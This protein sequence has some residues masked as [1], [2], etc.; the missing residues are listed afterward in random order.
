MSGK[1]VSLNILNFCVA[2]LSLLSV[3]YFQLLK[4]SELKMPGRQTEKQSVY[5]L[6]ED[7]QKAKLNILSKLPAFG[8]DNL[9]ADWTFLSFLQYFGD[10]EDRQQTG[11]SLSPEYYYV[12]LKHDPR[13]HQ[14]YLYLSTSSSLFA[15]Q[16]DRTV[17]LMDKALQSLSPEFDPNAYLLWLYKAVDQLLFLGDGQGARASYTNVVK[18]AK[19]NNDSDSKRLSILAA[20]SA[21]N[22]ASK[23][24]SKI[25]Q[26]NAW[27]LV[28]VNAFDNSTRQKAIKNIE[29]LGGRITFKKDGTV[30]VQHP[31]ED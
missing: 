19:F 20:K 25:A 29:D 27:L 2:I 11:Y 1:N 7:R 30:S 18:W 4:F 15:G 17:A 10:R 31:S 16:P 14:T 24:N 12:I 23:T 9:I 6:E 8:F 13:F 5:K 26:I 21:N 28:L 3:G 22:L